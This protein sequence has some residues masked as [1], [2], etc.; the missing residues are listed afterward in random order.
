MERKKLT[1]EELYKYE[2][3]ESEEEGDEWTP[4][5]RDA[6]KKNETK[7]EEKLNEC[8]YAQTTKFNYF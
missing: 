5:Q 7:K 6:K 4:G 2:S 3:E 8:K 1:P